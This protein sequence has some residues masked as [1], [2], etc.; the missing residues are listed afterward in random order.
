MIQLEDQ[1]VRAIRRFPGIASESLEGFALRGCLGKHRA[2]VPNCL[3]PNRPQAFYKRVVR[4]LP[5]SL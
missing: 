3:L 1:A 2:S 5:D 4:A